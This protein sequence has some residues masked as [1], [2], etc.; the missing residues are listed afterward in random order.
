MA[1]TDSA[2]A[3]RIQVAV[4]RLTAITLPTL[5]RPPVPLE[6]PP[7]SELV[8]W[9]AELYC[10]GLLSTFREMLRSFLFLVEN[11][12]VPASF[13][14]ARSLFEM[15]AH[16]YYVQKHVT[17]YLDAGDIEK[18]WAFLTEINMGSR[19]MQEEYGEAKDM[20][21][22]SAPR[23]I[24][25]IIRCYDEWLGHSGQASTEY[26]F[27]SE[28]AHPNMA[29]FS[30]YYTTNPGKSGF[31]VMTFHDPKREPERMPFSHVSIA[32]LSSM[33]FT[34]KLLEHIGETEVAPQVKAVLDTLP[35]LEQS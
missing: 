4:E 6:A 3:A 16:A 27:L 9:A 23:E 29:A 25:K 2:A 18:A 12:Y 31:A 17:Q 24:G 19:Y 33:H 8:N 28:F 7:T 14:I 21:L 15:G 10:F 34:A 5:A 30:H 11:G 32:V 20:Q 13:L 22:F 26:S 35:P 1:Y